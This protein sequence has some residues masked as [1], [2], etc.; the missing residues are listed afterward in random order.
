MP[1]VWL[2]VGN[3]L[4]M[5]RNARKTQEWLRRDDMPAMSLLFEFLADLLFEAGQR[6]FG[7]WIKAHEDLS[8]VIALVVMV[9]VNVLLIVVLNQ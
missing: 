3:R 7:K 9:V 8:A 6:P 2:F 5:L 4:R 1:G